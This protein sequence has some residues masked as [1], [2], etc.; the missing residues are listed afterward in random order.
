M[1][2]ERITNI[3]K[4]GSP[5]ACPYVSL[6]QEELKYYK[7]CGCVIVAEQYGFIYDIIYFVNDML[8]NVP[9]DK[10]GEC[11][12]AILQNIPIKNSENVNFWLATASCQ[13]LCDP[14][15]INDQSLKKVLA[16]IIEAL[17][18]ANSL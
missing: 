17:Q 13:E 7:G 11:A 10:F 12:V 2:E 4:N 3:L 1:F 9:S 18:E 6:T 5:S 16:R 15:K 8:D 14:I